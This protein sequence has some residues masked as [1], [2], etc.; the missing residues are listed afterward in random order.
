[1][2]KPPLAPIL[3]PLASAAALVGFA[4]LDQPRNPDEE[5]ARVP[6]EAYLEGHATGD[7]T[8]MARAFYPDA[9]LT[10]SRNDSLFTRSL[11]EYLSG[12]AGSP[13]ADEAQ[14]RRRIVSVDLFGSAGVGKIELDYPDAK[15]V[16]YMTLLERNGEWRIS[17]KSF[18][19]EPKSG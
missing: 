14:R 9:H 12:L 15:I 19:V 18:S 13:A 11:Q 7:P 5:A 10:W 6:L 3:L 17:H 1:M 4:V 8:V 2:R 16:D